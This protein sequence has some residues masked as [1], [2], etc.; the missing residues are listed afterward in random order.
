MATASEAKPSAWGVITNVV[1]K[2]AE[3]VKSAAKGVTKLP[4]KISEF[5][6]KSVQHVK[7]MKNGNDRNAQWD[8]TMPAGTDYGDLSY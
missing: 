3:L 4:S 8:M 1:H 7:D 5:V 6:K 2:T